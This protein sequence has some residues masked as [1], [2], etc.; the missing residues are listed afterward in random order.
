VPA[1]STARPQVAGSTV[2]EDDSV[3]L[4]T[5]DGRGID[6]VLILSIKT[7]VHAIGPGVIEGLLKALDLAEQH[8]RGLVIWSPDEPFSY[9]ADLQAMLPLFMSG[10]VKAIEPA[11]KALQDAMLRLRYAQVPTVAAVA[12]MALG[13]GCE[14]ASLRKTVLAGCRIN[15][16]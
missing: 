14:L 2:H 11:E 5:L 8:Y 16:Q 1:E 4:W 13:G 12:G 15:D 10:G 7:K 3:R 9:G 6:G